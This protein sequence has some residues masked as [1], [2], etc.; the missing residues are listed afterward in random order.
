[1]TT[2]ITPLRVRFAPSPTGYLHVGGARTALFNWL[3]ARSQ[4][5]CFVLRIEDTDLERSSEEM[6]RVILDSLQW[7]GI[8]W[9]EGPF[10]QAQRT[11][12]HR[13]EAERLFARGRAYRCFC[14]L[15]RLEESRRAAEREKRAWIYDRRCLRLPAEQKRALEQAGSASALR[16]R[17]P[18]EGET[19]FHD[20]IQGE[21]RFENRLLEDFVLLRSDG[22]PT[23]HLSVVADDID[24]RIT[25]V[26]RGADHISNTPKQILL[27]Q[28]FGHAVPE[29]GHLPLI[30]GPDKKRL[31]K[32]HGATAVEHYRVQGI[33][34][35]ALVN[36]LALLGWSPGVD[37]EV[38]QREELVRRFDLARV[39]R[40]NAVFDAAKLEWIN[41]QH[42][43]RMDLVKLAALVRQLLAE[44]GALDRTYA[45]EDGKLQD[46]VALLRSRCKTLRD[47]S[48]W[49]RAFF[50][51]DFELTPEGHEKYLSDPAILPVVRELADRYCALQDFSLAGT[52]RVLR[53]L[54]Q[55]KNT[56][57]GALIGAARVA[58]TGNAVAPGLFEVIVYLGRERTAA[59]LRRV[60]G[61][62]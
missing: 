61:D 20:L 17:V 22:M 9:D 11:A 6:T 8:D 51:D 36:Y 62:A 54:A 43:Q 58:L 48:G 31:S 30:L 1:M 44:E 29:I 14:P 7:L 53:E 18:D 39:N 28:A 56:K 50:L 40:A 52:E 4:G 47:F 37:Q 33:L 21:I 38:M 25:H 2:L 32:R 16:F 13:S 12:L 5:G 57:T 26:I 10:F 42:M 60:A 46:A 27:Y 55:E 23:Y 35:E 34:P 19:V 15:Q 3:L 41:A 45:R 59:R 24:M 49:G